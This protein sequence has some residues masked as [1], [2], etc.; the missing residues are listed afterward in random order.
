MLRN[1]FA[2][3]LAPFPA[4]ALLAALM[5][6]APQ[7]DRNIFEHPASM[8]VAT[9]LFVYA[10]SLLVA[11][12]ASLLFRNRGVFSLR[13]HAFAGAATALA[14]IG[15]VTLWDFIQGRSFLSGAAA[16]GAVALVLLGLLCGTAFWLIARP[17]R[18]AA[19][20]TGR[21]GRDRL[22]KTFE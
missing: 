1:I 22:L 12:P 4:A 3:L 5:A 16:I 13:A 21:A 10:L 19:M 11:V 7:H 8:F 9:C 18:R 14:G 20:G 17:D 15:L 6:I 2:F